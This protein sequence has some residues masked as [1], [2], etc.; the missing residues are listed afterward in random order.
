M[1]KF[2]KS[3]I[4]IFVSILSG[5]SY[6]GIYTIK[7]VTENI[8]EKYQKRVIETI[9]ASGKNKKELKKVL[10]HYK[11]NPQKLE[12]ASFLIANMKGHKYVE[13]GI[14]DSL[15]NQIEYNV[16]DYDNYH[17]IVDYLD[18]LEIEKGELHWDKVIEEK[19][20]ETV[21][22]DFLIS[23]IDLA[24]VAYKNLSWT[25][26]L[27]WKTFLEFVLPYRGS[28]EPLSDWRTYFWNEFSSFRDSTDEPLKLSYIINNKSKQIFTFKDV[29]YLHPT[30]QSLE[31]MLETGYGRC[32]DMTNFTIYAMR[33]NGLAVTSDYTPHWP[34]GTNNHAW[35]T[36]I[37]PGDK[38]IPF[39]GSE[40]NPGE[41]KLNRKI[42]KVY[43]KLF[44]EEDGSLA[45]QLDENEKVP[46]WLSGKS[47]RDVTDDY[48]ETSDV[49]LNLNPEKKWAY[50]AVFNSNE[51]KAIHW[52]KID[53]TGKTIFDKMG[54]DIAYLPTYY[55]EVDSVSEDY[56]KDKY[57]LKGADCPFILTNDELIEKFD[58]YPVE[59]RVKNDKGFVANR[60][61]KGGK[62][63]IKPECNY[64]LY[65]W[66]DNDWQPLVDSIDVQADSIIFDYNY[67][68]SLYKL[69]DEDK[70]PEVRIFT[71]EE[72]KQK[73]W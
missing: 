46:P 14:F 7:T 45:S 37:L 35:N 51:W 15:N 73:L 6:L 36:I 56:K 48:V 52:G 54:K 69:E 28:S 43:R 47:Y 41:Y 2:H 66:A 64:S 55:E 32:E 29:Y 30:D 59:E 39:M 13:V 49:V 20:L 33:G 9:E 31:E 1:N 34:D 68:N 27:G 11:D 10:Y 5:C 57:E 62:F 60:I 71:I 40:A 4:I 22:A 8:P 19:D 18:S 63:K 70:S 58:N 3:L 12:A 65:I 21:S 50:L 25:K 17:Q 38:V 42:A 44:F 23:H 26:N 72:R 67:P 53:S 24:F 16:L 61:A